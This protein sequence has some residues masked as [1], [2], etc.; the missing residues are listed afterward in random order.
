MPTITISQE[1]YSHLVTI[2]FTL[3]KYLSLKSADGPPNRFILRKE[4]AD[5]IGLK[6]HN[7]VGIIDV[8]NHNR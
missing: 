1:E 5:A 7:G 4:L 8:K 2:K 6:N 3:R